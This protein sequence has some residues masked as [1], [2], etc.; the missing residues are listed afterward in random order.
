MIFVGDYK[1]GKDEKNI[2][3][4]VLDSERVSE[5]KKE[6]STTSIKKKYFRFNI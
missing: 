5:Y 3:M 6:L 1:I 2:I 4:D